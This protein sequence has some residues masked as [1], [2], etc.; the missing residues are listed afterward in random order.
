MSDAFITAFGEYLPGEPVDNDHIE[1]FIGIIGDQISKYKKMVLRQNKIVS[2]HYACNKDGQFEFTVAQIAAKA[3]EDAIDNSQADISDLE[4]LATSCSIHD[5][6]IPGLASLVHGQ[7]GA[8][9][10]DISSHQSVCGSSI[11]A[12]RSAVNAIRLEEFKLACV[13]GSEIASRHFR[14][15]FYEGTQHF[16]QENALPLEQEFLRYTLSDGAGAAIIESR[17]NVNAISL[18]VKWIKARSFANRFSTCMIGGA[19]KEEGRVISWGNQESLQAAIEKGCFAL[20]QDL[21]LVYEMIPVW[22][23]HYLSLVEDGLIDPEKIDHVVSHYSS[24]S[25]KAEV[26]KLLTK[27]GVM[28]DEEKWFSNLTYKGNTGS[29]SIFILLNELFYSGKLKVGDS[30]LCHVPESGQAYNSFMLLEVV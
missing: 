7:L 6:I 1:D 17:P 10:I 14:P 29:A 12:M 8:D 22:V 28:I 4:F 2:R 9:R 5:S 20:S 30:V 25:L 13:S 26:V 3:I 21:K 24:E 16:K 19:I 23:G 27:A 11:M 15:T 18:K